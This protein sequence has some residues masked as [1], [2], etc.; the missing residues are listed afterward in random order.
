MLHSREAA[1]LAFSAKPRFL[2]FALGT[3][4]KTLTIVAADTKSC[5]WLAKNRPEMKSMLWDTLLSS[6]CLWFWFLFAVWVLFLFVCFTNCLTPAFF[7]QK[8]W[9]FSCLSGR[10]LDLRAD[11][12]LVALSIFTSL[13]LGLPVS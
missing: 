2:I 3:Q 10:A 11:L 12:R 6:L 8:L 1:S 9:S 7:T 4:K 13:N 5:I